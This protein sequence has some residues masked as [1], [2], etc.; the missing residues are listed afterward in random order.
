[1]TPLQHKFRVHEAAH[2]V[3]AM[4]LGCAVKG[5]TCPDLDKLGRTQ[6]TAAQKKS[7][8]ELLVINLAGAIAEDRFSGPPTKGATTDIANAEE[9]VGNSAE[10]RRAMADA[11]MLVKSRW[12]V[13]K[14][15]ADELKDQPTLEGEQLTGALHRALTN[16][17]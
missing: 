5:I 8:H 14:R 11:T 17:R 2:A 15:L 4:A 9:R 7:E 1:M 6:A 3:V 10:Y 12:A 13:I 16:R